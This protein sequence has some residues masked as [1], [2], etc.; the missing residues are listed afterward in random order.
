MRDMV[1]REVGTHLDDDRALRG[2]EG[3]S[4]AGLGHVG[5]LGGLRQNAGRDMQ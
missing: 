3:E 1:G 5:L 2:F 4:G